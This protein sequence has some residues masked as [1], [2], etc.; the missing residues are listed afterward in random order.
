M[1]QNEVRTENEQNERKRISEILTDALNSARKVW[2]TS[3]VLREAQRTASDSG[4]TYNNLDPVDQAKIDAVT[5]ALFSGK[6][7]EKSIATFRDMAAIALRLAGD[8]D[9]VDSET[10]LIRVVLSLNEKQFDE[11]KLGSLNK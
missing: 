6:E 9:H 1:A 4:N 8:N 2:S 7:S 10:I 11:T 3:Q 5:E